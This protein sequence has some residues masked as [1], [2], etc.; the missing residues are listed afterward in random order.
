MTVQGLGACVL[1]AL[2]RA[3]RHRDSDSSWLLFGPTEEPDERSDSEEFHNVA[4]KFA[5]E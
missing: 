2:M 4:W 3:D 1:T 5:A